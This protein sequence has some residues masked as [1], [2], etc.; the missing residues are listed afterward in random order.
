MKF[1]ASRKWAAGLVGAVALVLGTAQL[2][3]ATQAA[4]AATPQTS[5]TVN[6]AALEDFARE[7]QPNIYTNDV[8]KESRFYQQL[9][10]TELFRFPFPDG[11][12]AFATLQKGP[13]YLTFSNTGIIKQYTGL[14][15]IGRSLFK[16]SDVTVIVADVD[17]TVARVKASGGKVLMAPKDQPWGERQA[18]LSDPD[19]N[20]VQVSTHHGH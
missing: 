15:V 4:P 3:A 5:T 11:T 10:F 19:G 6:L 13:F 18:Y 7:G 2:T 14:W 9:G 16:S 12:V 20:L 1:T 17:A 8:D